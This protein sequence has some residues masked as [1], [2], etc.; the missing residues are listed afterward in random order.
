MHI[1]L[2]ILCWR[3][4]DSLSRTLPTYAR[5]KLF[6]QVDEAAL[7]L[8]EPEER[9]IAL[10][11]SYGLAV[12]TAP[13]NLGILG[14]FKWMAETLSHDVLL[15]LEDDCPL[16]EPES[17]VQRQLAIATRVVRTGDVNVF[18]LRHRFIPG[19]G[20][21]YTIIDKL[22]RYLPPDD[23]PKGEK[24][25]AQLRRGLRR[26]KFDR[27]RGNILYEMGDAYTNPYRLKALDHSERPAKPVRPFRRDKSPEALFPDGIEHHP[28]GYY[29][30]SA[31][32]MNWSNQSIL[33]RRDFFLEKIIAY[34]EA[35]P[36][37][38]RVNG[39]PDI[40]KELNSHY[41]R[42]SGWSIGMGDGLF[43]H[44]LPEHEESSDVG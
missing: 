8:P 38:R 30:V 21:R 35:H 29:R 22:H 4:H 27:L 14:G 24:L 15:L 16:V 44:E 17:E 31:R 33:I 39:F 13:Q 1:G 26:E 11:R 43:S 5:G 41:W 23:A 42:R 34:A 9:T 28:E 32:I 19:M 2:G 10:G 20:D 12:Y 7:F 36:S 37:Q 3:G 18:R 25:L 40:E 6:D